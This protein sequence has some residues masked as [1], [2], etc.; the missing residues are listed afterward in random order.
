VNLFELEGTLTALGQSFFDNNVMI[1]AYIVITDASGKRTMI[2]KVAVCNDIGAVLELGQNGRFY[3][4]RL[5]NNYNTIRCQLWGLRTDELA[6]VDQNNLRSQAGFHK[7]VYGILTTPIFGIG[8]IILFSGIN[9]LA[10]NFRYNRHE[11]FRGR[12]GRLPPPLP[13][14]AVRI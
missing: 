12:E 13:A 1:Y 11:M 4:D 3:V 9:L 14:Q 2:E 6:V 8:L 5:F 10:L 7:I